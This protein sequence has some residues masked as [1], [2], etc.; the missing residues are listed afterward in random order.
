MRTVHT[1]VLEAFVGPRPDGADAC[2]ENGNRRDARL[3]NLR[4]DSRSGN[5]QD[6]VRQR[7]HSMTR[8]SECPYGHPLVEPNLVASHE[9]IGRRACLACSRARA[10]AQQHKTRVTQELRDDYYTALS[11]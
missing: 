4:W 6:A 8:R 2:H 11:R 9:R 3:T 7:T 10:H 1:L 5:V